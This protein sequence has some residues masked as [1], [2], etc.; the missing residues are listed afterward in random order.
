MSGS[1]SAPA[2]AGWSPSP[3]G[4]AVAPSVV[5]L[6]GAVRSS[7]PPTPAGRR[8]RSGSGASSPPRPGPRR[9]LRPVGAPG[10]AR[11]REEGPC[12]GKGTVSPI[13]SNRGA[14]LATRRARAQRG[15]H[16]GADASHL[17]G[18]GAGPAGAGR[19]SGG[20]GRATGLHR[21]LLPEPGRRH[22]PVPVDRARDQDHPLRHLGPAHLPAAPR[23]AG[24]SG[25]LHPRDLRGPVPPGHRGEPRPGAAA[26]RRQRRQAPLRHPR[27]RRRPPSVRRRRARSRRSRWP[28]CGTRWSTC[29]WR[30]PTGRSGPTPPATTCPARWH[31]SPR[32]AR[33]ARRRPPDV[34][35]GQHDPDRIDDDRRRP[36]TATGPR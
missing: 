24:R 28:P 20:R 5:V 2:P 31:A 33:P 9:A 25:V 7:A 19:R 11:R 8:A 13:V 14:D 18:R 21:H 34:L 27:L 4:S 17:V 36:P 6:P 1:L 10:A 22:G 30:S 29:R 32:S 12:R 23:P 15:D 35:R 16:H 3:P 26:A